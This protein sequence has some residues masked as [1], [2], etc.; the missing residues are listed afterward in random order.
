M[1]RQLKRE[2]GVQQQGKR[3][4]KRGGSAKSKGLPGARDRIILPATHVLG[5]GDKQQDPSEALERLLEPNTGLEVQVVGRLV[6]DKERRVQVQRPGGRRSR[7]GQTEQSRAVGAATRRLPLPSPGERDAHT[8][9]AREVA[10]LLLL[11]GGG[12]AQAVQQAAGTSL[13]SVRV[14]RIQAAEQ[15][16]WLAA[17][18]S[19]TRPPPDRAR[20]ARQADAV[21]LVSF[22]SSGSN[23]IPPEG[24]LSH[25]L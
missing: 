1:Q 15:G 19:P 6:Q 16:R 12:E 24:E 2:H 21:C 11:H 20:Q 10:G 5:V 23:Q 14:Q 9:A 13:R 18:W 3:Q 7:A 17:S 8:P 4:G 22:S 25:K